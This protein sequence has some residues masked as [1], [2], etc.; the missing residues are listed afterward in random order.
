[1]MA[2]HRFSTDRYDNDDDDEDE[3]QINVFDRTHHLDSC[4]IPIRS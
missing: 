1:M 4:S 3:L 2:L